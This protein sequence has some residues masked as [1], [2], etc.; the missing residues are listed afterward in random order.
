MTFTKYLLFYNK[1]MSILVK[2]S[3]GRKK[4][5]SIDRNGRI[6]RARNENENSSC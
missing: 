2:K 1:V 4:K 3:F 6:E 5:D